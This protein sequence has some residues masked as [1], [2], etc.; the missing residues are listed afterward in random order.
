[1]MRLKDD[2]VTIMLAACDGGL[3]KLSVRWWDDPA[4]VVVMAARGYPGEVVRGSEI[5]GLDLARAVEGVELFHASTAFKGGK[6]V[7]AGGRVLNIA[8]RGSTVV[9][10]R[11]RAYQAIDLI[12]WPEG[13]YRRDIG[14]RAMCKQ[15]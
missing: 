1:M 11:E 10:A 13:F 2:I 7:S 14:S 5:G 15:T 3:G 12:S 6:I 8:A 4:L 9:Q